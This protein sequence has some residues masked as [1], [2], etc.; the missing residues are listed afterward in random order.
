MS[1]NAIARLGYES[2]CTDVIGP[3]GLHCWKLALSFR[4]FGL[5]KKYDFDPV[6]GLLVLAHGNEIG[7]RVTDERD[8]LS[9]N[10][11]NGNV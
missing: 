9:M 10:F 2:D 8:W 6:L 11:E 3:F 7:S 4:L 5:M 1:R